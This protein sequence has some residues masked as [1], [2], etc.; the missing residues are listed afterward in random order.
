MSLLCRLLALLVSGPTELIAGMIGLFL[1]IGGIRLLIL[2]LYLLLH[3]SH[4]SLAILVLALLALLRTE[5]CDLLL[6]F[7]GQFFPFVDRVPP[8]LNLDILV[9]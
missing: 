1:V 5:I 9:P 8:I 6:L 7:V 2:V 4:L 3:C